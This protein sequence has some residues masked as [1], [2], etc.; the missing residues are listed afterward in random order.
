MR[1]FWRRNLK[2]PPGP[3]KLGGDC[4]IR[5]QAPRLLSTCG[6]PAKKVSSD[7]SGIFVQFCAFWMG[8]GW[9]SSKSREN[10]KSVR[11]LLLQKW[12]NIHMGC[13]G[14]S[15][16]REHCHSFPQCGCHFAVTLVVHLYGKALRSPIW[17]LLEGLCFIKKGGLLY[18]N[19]WS[20]PAP[21]KQRA[22]LAHE[23]AC[24]LIAR[25]HL[26]P[27]NIC[28]ATVSAGLILLHLVCSL[29]FTPTGRGVAA[30]FVHCQGRGRIFSGWSVPPW[31]E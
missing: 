17:Q 21:A 6:F 23:M 31:W 29:C 10:L 13:W 16:P 27:A 30:P 9:K 1:R 20:G 8:N 5:Y 15:L 2:V 22:G 28:T 19:I 11:Q 12:Q 26:F 25:G 7:R 4:S 3:I 18:Q 24:A 14:P